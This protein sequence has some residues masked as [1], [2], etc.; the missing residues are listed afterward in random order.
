M[1]VQEK[2]E[3]WGVTRE[4][5]G[6]EIQATVTLEMGLVLSIAVTGLFADV[7]LKL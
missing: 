5:G 2:G 7:S 1:Q 4:E 6:G 3:G